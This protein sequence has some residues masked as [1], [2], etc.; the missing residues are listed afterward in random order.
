MGWRIL[1]LASRV[2]AL[3][4]LL[5]LVVPRVQA[6]LRPKSPPTESM[7]VASKALDPVEA[8]SEPPK[9]PVVAT[10][11]RERLLAAAY[12]LRGIPY[13]WG[14]KGPDEYDCSGFTRAA[15]AVVGVDLP[16]GS[17]NQAE[18][19]QPLTSFDDLTPGDL[20]FYRWHGGEGVE[21]VTIYV[22]D[23]WAIGT[24]SPGQPKEVVVYPLA[25][26]LRV[27]DTVITFRHIELLDE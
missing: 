4:L 3:V 15:Y 26:D 18:G 14:A 11:D 2:L 1:V 8:A 21:H 12:S 19:E 5:I 7:R 27:P 23:G 17:F 9:A 13:K 25:N 10:I 16:D 20:L 24:G 6:A 22:G